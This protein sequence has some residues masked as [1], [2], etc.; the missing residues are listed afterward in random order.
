MRVC[1]CL[2]SR[3]REGVG[4]KR[5]FQQAARTAAVMRCCRMRS[6][7]RASAAPRFSRQCT[8]RFWERSGMFSSVR[9]VSAIGSRRATSGTR[10][11]AILQWAARRIGRQSL[12]VFVQRRFQPTHASWSGRRTLCASKM[13]NA[14]AVHLRCPLPLGELVLNWSCCRS[15][16]R[17]RI[18]PRRPLGCPDGR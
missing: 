12:A 17:C 14:L 6:S 10:L 8:V 5:L 1:R 13:D 15:A 2:P 3:D 11:D 4:S 18:G 9:S 16:R 7:A